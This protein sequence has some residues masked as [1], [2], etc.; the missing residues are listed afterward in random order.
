MVNLKLSVVDWHVYAICVLVRMEF[1]AILASEIVSIQN[2]QGIR[3][4][5]TIPDGNIREFLSAI[6]AA[7]RSAFGGNRLPSPWAM[8]VL[9]IGGLWKEDALAIGGLGNI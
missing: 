2:T 6:I 8:T 3:I 7:V 4:P 9:N 1:A 5:S